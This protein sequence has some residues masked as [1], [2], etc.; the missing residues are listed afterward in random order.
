[1]HT[2]V[3]AT[4]TL[5]TVS[6]IRDLTDA[7]A[8]ERAAPPHFLAI[9][10]STAHNADALR[11]HV[12][13]TGAGAIHGGTSCLGVMAGGRMCSDDGRGMGLFA[14]WDDDGAYGTGIAPIGDN[15]RGAASLAVT[16]ALEAAG[17]VGE[18]PDLVWLTAAPGTE[19]S[20]IAGIEDVVGS[21]A[22][23]VGGSAADN[24]LSGAWQVFDGEMTL[25]AGVAVSVLFPSSRVSTA[26]QSGYAPT[27]TAGRVTGV[28]RRCVREIDG[29]P[30][31]EV[32]S[33]WTKGAVAP[34]AS[35]GPEMILSASTFHPLGRHVGEIADVPF[36]LLTHPAAANPDGSIELF[37]DVEEGEELTLMSGSA[38]SLVSRAGRVASLS[39]KRGGLVAS[40]I[41]GA[42]VIFCGGCMLA[43]RDRM[44]E[45]A[46]EVDRALGGAP[47]L[48]IF[49]FGEQGAV[50]GE[51]N[52]HGNLMISCVTFAR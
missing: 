11:E 10:T 44:D 2:L 37:A 22:P 5:D 48:G 33:G 45:V 47:S 19:E 31:M 40:D 38:D 49:T 51:S 14:L 27:E 43:V 20:L 17:R 15:P 46:S 23:I 30:A 39:V 4:D 25:G 7:L 50:L 26:Y 1:M 13:A 52:R 35:A 42:L 3:R 6:A 34:D 28:E 21:N 36:Y 41:A 12:A 24:D 9:Y 16:R 29:R 18:A 8:A 32:Y